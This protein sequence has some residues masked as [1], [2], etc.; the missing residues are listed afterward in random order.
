L[1]IALKGTYLVDH[2][3]HSMV[4]RKVCGVV[5][6]LGTSQAVE[7]ADW[8]A[9][10]TVALKGTYLVDHSAHSMVVRKVCGVVASLGT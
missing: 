2:S 1:K 6:S 9:V 5:A 7:K 10:L 8:R 3:A 4:V